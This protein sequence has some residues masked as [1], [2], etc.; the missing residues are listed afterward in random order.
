[1][2]V[3]RTVLEGGVASDVAIVRDA[4]GHE[5]VIKQ[6]LP[7]LKVA[8]DWRCDPARS[9]QEVA[10]LRTAPALIGGDSVPRVLW[11]DPAQHRFA[12][13]RIDPGLENWQSQLMAGKVSLATAARVGELLG[14]LQYQSARAPQLAEPFG[15]R[16]FFERLRIEPFFHR[17]AAKNPQAR[18]AI[19]HVIE[20]LR[21]PGQVLVHGD[22]SPKNML[23]RDDRAVI[24]DWEV[25]HWG[26]PR[27]DV[28]FCLTHLW[29]SGCRA[30]QNRN[31]YR[32][33]CSAF[34]V[35]YAQHG[36]VAGADQATTALIAC[37]VLARLDGDSPVNY[38]DDL[39]VNG[40]RQTALRLLHGPAPPWAAMFDE[41]L[42]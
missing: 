40:L 28:A 41:L 37:L 13:E 5:I 36:V 9:S 21:S 2:N 6:A 18:A 4:Q 34:S 10:A 35:G 23:V 15:N 12:M 24:L 39:D 42:S 8:A 16:E 20:L 22:Y 17:S 38:L 31:L 26:D 27:F 1:M 3:D 29:L 7:R 32:E 25:V 33:A 11:V 19:E 14:Q 30:G